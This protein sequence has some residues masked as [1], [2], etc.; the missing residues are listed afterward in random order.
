M[1]ETRVEGIE[2]ERERERYRSDSG[3]MVRSIL[4][5]LIDA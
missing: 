2:K 1:G 5:W 4:E 3:T